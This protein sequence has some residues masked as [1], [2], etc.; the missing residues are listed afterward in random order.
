MTHSCVVSF[1]SETKSLKLG[2]D[3]LIL[4]KNSFGFSGYNFPNQIIFQ[5]V[6]VKDIQGLEVDNPG[7]RISVVHIIGKVCSRVSQ[8]IGQK[9]TKFGKRAEFQ[10][11]WRAFVKPRTSKNYIIIFFI[12]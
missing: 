8:Y 7:V 11:S 9:F 3:F 2:I 10:G 12:R 4:V 5:T 6:W 1:S